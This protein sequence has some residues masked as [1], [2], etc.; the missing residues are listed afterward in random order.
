MEKEEARSKAREMLEKAESESREFT[1]EERA[2]YQRLLDIIDAEEP[3]GKLIPSND[4]EDGEFR[5]LGE[6]VKAVVERDPRLLRAG[7]SAGTPAEG[8][9][10]IPE[11]F[12]PGI[13]DAIAVQG[14]IR[15]RATVLP[16]GDPP[17]AKLSMP[18][19]DYA[20]G[21]LAGVSVAWTG[22]GEEKQET[23]ASFKEITLEPKEVSAHVVV[24]D[25]LLRN[26]P[27][28]EVVLRNLLANA[29]SIAEEAAFLSGG[30]TTE[31]TGIIGS[32][33]TIDVPRDGAGGITYG[34]LTT[35]LSSSIGDGKIWIASMSVLPELMEMEDSAGHLIWQPN[36]AQ[37]YPGTLFGLPLVLSEN[38]PTL[39]NP[40]DVMLISPKAYY[41]YDGVGLSV[42]V[43]EHVYFVNNKSVLKV[44]K[45]VDGKPGLL[46]PITLADGSTRVS[47]FVT[48]GNPA[49]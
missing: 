48:L 27:Q 8:G 5:T 6:F 49:S 37:G 23:S 28:V 24:T 38:S 44:F 33:A 40:G 47:P 29:I 45:S 3:R 16:A 41:I 46:S 15:S 17:E 39:G 36:A 13:L 35:M 30:G 11:K 19:L 14:V 21:R 20:K 7:Q 42:A 1:T 31:P 9:Y 12:M 25:K 10:L 2:E 4:K 18:V 34:D 43:S 22:E 32:A 26:A